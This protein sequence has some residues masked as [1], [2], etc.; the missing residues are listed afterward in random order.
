MQQ[1]VP[2]QDGRTP[3]PKWTFEDYRQGKIPIPPFLYS[4]RMLEYIYPVSFANPD[5]PTVK[6]WLAPTGLSQTLQLEKDSHFLWEGITSCVQYKAT[7]AQ[8]GDSD[9]LLY[10]DLLISNLSY[11][12][13]F[14]NVSL[15]VRD[16]TGAGPNPQYFRDPVL[17]G[18]NTILRFQLGTRNGVPYT[19]GMGPYQFI[20]FGRKVYGV[21]DEEYR[22]S[23]K[24]QWYSYGCPVGT[25]VTPANIQMPRDN[26]EVISYTRM[27]SDA[28]FV[29]RRISAT[30]VMLGI[31]N[32]A[33]YV[34]PVE[35][36]FNIRISSLG[37]SFF[38]K[39]LNIRNVSGGFNNA[40]F[41]AKGVTT[42]QYY[43][44]ASPFILASPLFIPRNSVLELRAE[45]NAT[46]TAASGYLSLE[47]FKIYD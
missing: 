40:Q 19:E 4:K 9:I 16:Q 47:G 37:R 46:A 28:D 31:A 23:R 32:Y 45:S 8:G 7:G 39:K 21:T 35:Y 44:L 15:C 14:S 25:V 17:I 22:L 42:Q 43:P 2:G 34:N 29:C 18:P 24:R 11:G 20:L 1:N 26:Q 6:S 36:I 5:F 3:N 41:L 12:D 10:R 13:S 30:E 27:F 33:A 38:N